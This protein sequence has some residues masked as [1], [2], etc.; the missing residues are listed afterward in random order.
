MRILK[1]FFRDE[2]KT[3]VDIVECWEVRWYSRHNSFRYPDAIP[4]IRVFTSQEDALEFKRALHDAFKTLR[5]TSGIAVDVMK[6][7]I[8]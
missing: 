5:Y 7:E 3:S 2:Q 1:L 8:D 4:E 6:Q